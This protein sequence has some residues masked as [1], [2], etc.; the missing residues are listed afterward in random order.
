MEIGKSQIYFAAES[1]V[2]I[3]TESVSISITI[4]SRV[5]N[6]LITESTIGYQYGTIE[7]CKRNMGLICRDYL[8]S[9]TEV[10]LFTRVLV[11]LDE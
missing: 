7:H 5:R 10:L 1:I 4:D 3:D 6:I 8:I 9:W 11:Q 2:D